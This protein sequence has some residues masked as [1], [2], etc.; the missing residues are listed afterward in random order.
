[1]ASLVS[2]SPGP[3]RL[4]DYQEHSLQTHRLAYIFFQLDFELL[5]SNKDLSR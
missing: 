4:A 3:S 5:A 1:M 2:I